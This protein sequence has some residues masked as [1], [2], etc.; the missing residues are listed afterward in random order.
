MMKTN[1]QL[2][3]IPTCHLDFKT[4]PCNPEPPICSLERSASAVRDSQP[5]GENGALG[6]I[7]RSGVFACMRLKHLCVIAAADLGAE[8]F[9]FA[10]IV[11]VLLTLLVGI[12]W[13]GR[14]YNVYETITRAARE[15]ARYAVLPNSVAAGN[16]FP[17]NLTPSCSSNTNTFNNHIVP[18]LISDNLDPSQ[19]KD[20]CQMTQWLENTSPKQ[21][22]VSISF[23]YPVHMAIPFTSLNMTTFN[24]RTQAQMRLENQPLYGCPY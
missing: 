16:T 9:E 5:E 19:V 12:I 21:C 22:G 15:G 7:K 24:I 3:P 18:V 8:V 13:I 23:S 2:L 17:D 10:I 20:Y 4:D 14:A 6:I 11:P 1:E